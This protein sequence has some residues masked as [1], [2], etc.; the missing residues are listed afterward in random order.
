MRC[1]T[2]GLTLVFVLL[3]SPAALA[4]SDSLR[5]APRA[6]VS[7]RLAPPEAGHHHCS[8]FYEGA[9]RG[10]AAWLSAYGDYLL[11]ES[12]AAE[13]WQHVE[14]KHY[15]NQLK[16]RATAL[17]RKRILSEY[18]ENERLLRRSRKEAAK[19]LWP[20]KYL[21]LAHMYRLDENEFNPVTGQINWPALVAGPRYAAQ[22]RQLD[23]LMDQGVRYGAAEGPHFCAQVAKACAIFRNQLRQQAA[24]DHPST[25]G[26]YLAVQH[27]LLGLKYAPYLM[28]QT[29]VAGALAAN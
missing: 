17:A 16:K 9:L 3:A 13:V 25:R 23:A 18:R 12:Q 15:D 7:R 10:E 21:E 26:E 29:E 19:Q 24:E 6:P 4:Q 28:A 1:T 5:L 20:E 14:S 8:T 22:R 27:F 2:T 11:D